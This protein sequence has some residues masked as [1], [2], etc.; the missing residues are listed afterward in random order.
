MIASSS[1]ASTGAWVWS[2]VIHQ[3][4]RHPRS[5]GAVSESQT[6]P[7]SVSFMDVPALAFEG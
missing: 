2:E 4:R 5:A 3:R 1:S 6:L 7:K